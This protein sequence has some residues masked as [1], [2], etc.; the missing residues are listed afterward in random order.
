MLY[1]SNT[2][3]TEEEEKRNPN[4]IHFEKE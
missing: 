1:Y 2:Q 3:Q 4:K